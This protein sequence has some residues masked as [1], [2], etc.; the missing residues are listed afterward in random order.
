MRNLDKDDPDTQ[1]YIYEKLQERLSI[2]VFRLDFI[3]TIKTKSGE[4]KKI[5]VEIQKAW[6][7]LAGRLQFPMGLGIGPRGRRGSLNFNSAEPPPI[8][9]C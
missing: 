4:N 8:P 9:S 3:A 2:N 5:L 1:E 7:E 6:N